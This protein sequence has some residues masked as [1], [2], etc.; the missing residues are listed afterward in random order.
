MKEN[1][2]GKEI[3]KETIEK[4]KK[5]LLNKKEMINANIQSMKHED[6][7]NTGLIDYEAN[8]VNILALV[9][10]GNSNLLRIDNALIRIEKGNYGHCFD[11]GNSIDEGLLENIPE[12]TI[13]RSCASDRQKKEKR[14]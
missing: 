13:C 1:E 3:S 14:K 6:T 10:H 8:F 9:N 7:T 12:I 2:I 5:K 11:C 4:C